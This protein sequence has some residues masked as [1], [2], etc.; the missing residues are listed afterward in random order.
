VYNITCLSSRIFLV[1]QGHYVLVLVDLVYFDSL[2]ALINLT[3]DE[4]LPRGNIPLKAL[5]QQ[6][7]KND[8]LKEI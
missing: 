2:L 5:P 4:G 8:T 6:V 3:L 1:S 7:F